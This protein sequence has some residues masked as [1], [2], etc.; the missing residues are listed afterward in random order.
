VRI[1]KLRIFTL[2]FAVLVLLASYGLAWL[3]T[4][5]FKPPLASAGSIGTTSFLIAGSSRFPCGFIR[6][7][8][9]IHSPP[10]GAPRE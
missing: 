10:R 6:S 4:Y 9:A 8:S 1:R 2:C 3:R 5:A 7:S